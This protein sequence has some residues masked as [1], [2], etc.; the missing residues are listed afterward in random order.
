MLQGPTP[1]P[2]PIGT[3]RSARGTAIAQ[4]G[5]MAK[6]NPDTALTRPL[7]WVALVTLLL[8]DH[9]LKGAGI[10][11]GA[12][13]GKLS[14]VA[15]LVVAPI[16][17]AALFR[18]TTHRGAAL[19]MGAVGL[20][21]AAI[22]LSPLAAAPFELLLGWRVWT[23]PTDLV[24]LPALAG[25]WSLMST[26][27]EARSRHL[28]HAALALGAFA[29]M[30]TSQDSTGESCST[31]GDC[32]YSVTDESPLLC[33]DGACVDMEFDEDHCGA[34]GRTCGADQTCQYGRCER[35]TTSQH[36]AP[37]VHDASID[38]RAWTTTLDHLTIA[39]GHVLITN[40]SR[41]AE[42]VRVTRVASPGALDC[43]QL[44]EDPEAAIADVAFDAPVEIPL[45]SF[46]HA[47]LASRGSC[48]ALYVEHPEAG[49]GL[50]TLSADAPFA[51]IRFV[52]TTTP[53]FVESEGPGVLR[54]VR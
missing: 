35:P 49:F 38:P 3:R 21:F 2:G 22:N 50:V 52:D 6:C 10:L 12:V 16:V 33:C 15:G 37:V 51:V 17:V 18:V 41:E 27:T 42:V 13:T 46:G 30:A 40:A 36:V 26:R 23:D 53:R 43:A 47:S 8:N 1:A 54:V 14:D 32:E 5:S 24:T 7:F 4:A 34:C 44:A 39:E 19:S 28:T 31:D 20:V 48:D 25:A 11:P 45:A 9:V 29:C